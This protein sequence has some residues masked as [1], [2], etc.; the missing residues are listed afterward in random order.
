MTVTAHM[1]HPRPAR[2]VV[3]GIGVLLCASV[4]AA[5]DSGG[6]SG[7]TQPAPHTSTFS[8]GAFDSIP[9]Y[10]GSS[11]AGGRSHDKGVTVQSFEVSSATPRAVLQW[12]AS[13]LKSWDLIQ[14]P[15]ASG[16]ADWRGEWQ[17]NQRRLLISAAP[18]PALGNPASA[19][20]T[21]QFSLELGDPGA[22]V[23]GSSAG[24][25]S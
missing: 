17:R 16:S 15:E 23:N 12:Y 19:V 6:S 7:S 5:C 1:A 18:S 13:R 4:A 9:R 11:A 10:P 2:L 25:S 20:S 22:S 21:T 8:K 3:M 14:R 24:T